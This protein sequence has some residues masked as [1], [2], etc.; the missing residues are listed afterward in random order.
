MSFFN[1][2]KKNNRIRTT[3]DF[4]RVFGISSLDELPEI[5]IPKGGSAEAET[6]L[7]IEE[8]SCAC[9]DSDE[10]TDETGTAD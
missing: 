3:P 10:S 2:I 1:F 7:P 8:A 6:I 4:L 9:P 5:S